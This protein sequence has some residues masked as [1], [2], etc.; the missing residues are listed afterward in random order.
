MVLTVSFVLSPVTGLVCHRRLRKLPSAN[1]T[2]ASGRQDHTTSP[3]AGR[4]SRQQRRLRPSHPA[5]YVRDDR[6]TPLRGNGTA[7]DIDLIWGKREEESFCN[8]DWTGQ[9]TLIRLNKSPASRMELLRRGACHRAATAKSKRSGVASGR[10]A[11]RYTGAIRVRF[12]A[13]ERT[14]STRAATSEKCQ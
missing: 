8:R 14:F 10:Y 3:S 5:S 13:D 12:A 6:E 1:L 2:P 9:I 11:V 7:S 4:R